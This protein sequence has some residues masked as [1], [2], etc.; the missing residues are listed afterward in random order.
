MLLD[1]KSDRTMLSK[2]YTGYYD[3]IEFLR[4]I[5]QTTLGFDMIRSLSGTNYILMKSYK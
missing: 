4:I 5:W 1:K 3:L 2:Q